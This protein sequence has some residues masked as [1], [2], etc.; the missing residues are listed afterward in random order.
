MFY[1]LAER[2]NTK[3]IGLR[4]FFEENDYRQLKSEATFNDLVMLAE[5]WN[6]VY[7]QNTDFFNEKELKNLFILNYS[8]NKVWTQFI[9]AYYLYNKNDNGIIE[10]TASFERFLEKAIAFITAYS[11]LDMDTSDFRV[12]IDSEMKNIVNGREIEFTNSNLY[13]YTK[14]LKLPIKY[15]IISEKGAGI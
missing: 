7:N 10:D 2:N 1:K 4:R 14:K 3:R 11:M 8:T 13:H 15:D 6:N 9:S 12:P 5:F